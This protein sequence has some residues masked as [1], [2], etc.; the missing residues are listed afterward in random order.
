MQ[1]FRRKILKTEKFIT[2]INQMIKI[3]RNQLKAYLESTNQMQ[4]VGFSVNEIYR[5]YFDREKLLYDNL[6]KLENKG[7]LC[8]GYLWS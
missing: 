6:N 3:T 8:H 1:Y 2:E 5:L 4:A 7:N